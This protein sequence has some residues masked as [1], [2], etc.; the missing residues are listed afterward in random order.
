MTGWKNSIFYADDGNI[1][2]PLSGDDTYYLIIKISDDFATIIGINTKPDSKVIVQK[3]LQNIQEI[4]KT[5]DRIFK[6]ILFDGNITECENT[7][8][9][10][11][12]HYK[13][14]DTQ[15]NQPFDIEDNEKIRNEHSEFTE[16]IINLFFEQ[17]TKKIS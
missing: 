7:T 3:I 17:L 11:Q 14:I 4:K 15:F 13:V 2:I 12:K 1:W 6:N 8:P 5:I 10:H 16:I 9:C